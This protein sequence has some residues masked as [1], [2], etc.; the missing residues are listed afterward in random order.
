MVMGPTD[1][2]PE[3]DGRYVV[4]LPDSYCRCSYPS[5]FF[6]KDR[7]L[8]GHTNAHY[9]DDDQY[10][11]PGRLIVVPISWLYGGAKNM[12]PSDHLRKNFPIT[13]Y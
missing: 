1:P 12:K 5:A 10:V 6:H 4:D 11:M 13:R 2:A 7:L 3:R 9:T 8:V